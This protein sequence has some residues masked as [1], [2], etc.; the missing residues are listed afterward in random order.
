M[1]QARLRKAKTVGRGLAK[2]AAA[3]LGGGAV[4][5]SVSVLL[6]LR[7]NTRCDYCDLPGQAGDEMT[8]AQAFRLLEVLVRAGTFR[9]GL[10]G[11]EPLVRDDV[12]AIARHA[13]GLGLLT[14]VV[15][16]GLRLE[17]RVDDVMDVDFLLCTVEG[18]EALH[19]RQRGA[20]AYRKALAGLDAVRRRGGP[21]LG[22]VCPVHAGNVDAL[23]EPLRLAESL[24]ARMFYQPV[25]IREDWRGPAYEDLVPQDRLAD[26]F[27]Q[28]I[29][30]K[31]AG[32]PIGNSTPFLRIVTAGPPTFQSACPAGRFVVTIL[33]DLRVVPCCVV[34]FD[35]SV[36]LDLDRPEEAVARLRK[37]DC[38]GCFVAS[39]IE[40]HFLLKPDPVAVWETLAWK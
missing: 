34:P 36:P 13:R 38:E 22:L 18:D 21:A 26:A 25:Q 30:W 27:R 15:T 3:R 10:S 19:D 14:S 7:C 12:G 35:R 2:L 6:T 24:G 9:V 1:D 31:K 40:N 28:L 11:G 33:P 32:R 4:W 39:Y 16:N 17:E 8:T 29:A 5:S 37:P 20:G 23:E